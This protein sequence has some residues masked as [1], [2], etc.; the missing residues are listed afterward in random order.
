MARNTDRRR[1][2]CAKNCPGWPETMRS[3]WGGPVV[4]CACGARRYRPVSV[5]R[6]L[7]MG[8]TRHAKGTRLTERLRAA[9][10]RLSC[11][12]LGMMLYAFLIIFGSLSWVVWRFV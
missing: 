9:W 10:R 8:A 6:R 12:D 4:T 7:W 2:R 1:L 5:P 11:L 3:T